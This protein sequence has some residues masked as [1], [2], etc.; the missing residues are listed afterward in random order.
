MRLSDY[1]RYHFRELIPPR[2][3]AEVC[4]PELAEILDHCASTPQQVLFP[5]G[6]ITNHNR[7]FGIRTDNVPLLTLINDTI[8]A[9]ASNGG[10]HLSLSL[11]ATTTTDDDKAW[12]LFCDYYGQADMDLLF[13]YVA[14]H[15]QKAISLPERKDIYLTIAVREEFKQN[16]GLDG[17][18]S[19]LG[20]RLGVSPNCIQVSPWVVCEYRGTTQGRLKEDSGRPARILSML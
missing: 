20:R 4:A 17:M 3:V 12:R 1:T 14:K 19:Q 10:R 18:S 11:G 6:I 8:L 7:I 5:R 16:Y 2:D 13:S 15:L 9:E